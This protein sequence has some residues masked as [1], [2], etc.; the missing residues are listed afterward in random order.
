MNRFLLLLLPA[1]LFAGQAR[2]A[3]LGEFD[4]KV[5][6]QLHAG[7]PWSPAERNLPLA[8][9]AWLRTGAS[10][11]LEIEL[12]DG[13][14]WRLG[15]DSQVEISDYTRLSTGQRV[16]ILSLDRGVAY[17]TGEPGGADTLTLVAPGAQVTLLHG[18]RVRLQVDA[19]VSRISVIEGV[20]RFSCPAAELDVREGQTVR[21]D[22]ANTARFW[23]DREVPSYDLDR[24][25]EDRDKT[26]ATSSSGSHVAQRYGVVDLDA[27]GEWVQTDLGAVWKPK[28]AEGWAPFQNG[29]WRWYDALGYTW[30]S[31]E[32]W[33]WVPYHHGRWTRKGD[34]GWVWVPA[35][36]PVF[37]PGDVYWLYNAKLVGW[38]PLA[39][40]E[41]WLPSTAPEQFLNVNT[42]YANFQQDAHAIDPAGFKDRPKEPLG[43]AVF[44]VALP[45][46]A[47]PASRLEATRPVLRVGAT[48]IQA[49]V[50]GTTFPDTTEVPPPPLPLPPAIITNPASDGPPTVSSGPPPDPGPPG[51][52]MQVI[53]PVPVYTG[54][55]VLNPPEHPDYSRRNPNSPQG[56]KGTSSQ[57]TPVSTPLSIP[58]GG[59]PPPAKRTTPLPPAGNPGAS[60]K[61]APTPP[62]PATTTTTTTPPPTV[63]APPRANPLPHPG[64]IPSNP[65]L[66]RPAPVP[67]PVSR[68]IPRLPKPEA[69]PESRPEARPAPKVESKAE[70][71]AD[72]K[73]DTAQPKKP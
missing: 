32:T 10:S 51:P 35:V 12:D 2:Y 53:Y 61:P 13:S 33:G 1:A 14:A 67:I 70:A 28:V 59:T 5:E 40:G 60:S 31:D 46:P 48:R 4:G 56:S 34:L 43:V 66:D 37:K 58:G 21:V 6:V 3:R 8:E 9:S 27:A 25:S 22:P 47:F 50:P 64:S 38:G 72:S 49:V 23:L 57:S 62:V 18:A 24:W 52:P 15:P 20:V 30:V 29:R 44:A 54:I 68:E 73:P 65:S 17:F 39:P 55:I 11:R 16:T 69:K 63:P 45:S 26:L 7:D 42:T 71:K 19:T 41:D 36:S